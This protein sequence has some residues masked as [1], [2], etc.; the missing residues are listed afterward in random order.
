MCKSYQAYCTTSRCLL[1]AATTEEEEKTTPFGVNTKNSLKKTPVGY[2]QQQQ[3]HDALMM[4]A[5][6]C[7]QPTM[8]TIRVTLS[9]CVA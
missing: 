8:R 5:A 4:W 6:M 7:E 2:Q 1:Q 9:V 3:Q